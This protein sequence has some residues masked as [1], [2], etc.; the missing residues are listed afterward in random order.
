VS[1]P[2]YAARLRSG[3]WQTAQLWR[4]LRGHGQVIGFAT[5]LTLLATA[6]GL[7]QPMLVR[8]VIDAAQAGTIAAGLVTTLLAVLVGQAAI[9]AFG[10][11]LLDRTSEGILLSLRLRLIGHLIRLHMRVYDRQRIGDLI[12]RTSTDTTIVR[13]A[14][15]NSFS[16]LITN[17]IGV[18]GAVALMVWLDPL[19]FLLVL[20]VVSVASAMMLT[21]LVRIR[22]TSARGQASIGGMTAELERAL[23]AIRT[24]RACRAEQREAERI[25]ARAC[26][27]NRAGVRMAKLDSVIA[28][29]IELAVNGSILV[30]LLIGGLRVAHGSMSL[31]DLVAFLLYVTYL[32]VPLS[33]LFHAMAT[34]QRGLGAL[35]RVNSVFAMPCEPDESLP[36]GAQLA[37]P[38][39]RPVADPTPAVEFRDV[40]FGY[41]DRP[42]LRGVSFAVP[43]RGYIA[44]VGRSGAG[45]STIF[46]LIERFYEHDSGE[47]R[48]DGRQARSMKRSDARALVNLVEQQAPVLHGTLRDNITYAVPDAPEDELRW[49]VKAASLQELVAR[50]PRG[51]DTE[52]G[53]HGSALSGG[54]RQRVAIARAL[55]ARPAVLLMDEPTSQL[56]T[57]NEVALTAVMREVASECALFVI[58]HRVST[59]RAADEII[60]LDEGKVV[61]T[62]RHV[63]LVRTN[64]KY[65]RLTSSGLEHDL[66][67]KPD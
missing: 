4:L 61:A 19:L 14:A 49:A 67:S 7:L 59:V 56:D 39:L 65:Q 17:A 44:L 6:A 20:L 9:E 51:L 13:E 38:A 45:K 8:Q 46:E 3:G 50:L 26:D 55:L 11:Y 22:A 37:R 16:D 36:S 54:E 35:E 2:G 43:R 40:W 29:A 52:V 47:I 58:A 32:V 57:V 66:A 41:T 21:V 34:V 33:S 64:A 63:D 5:L 30:V 60:V 12:S 18:L 48:I 25:G 1:E 42:V 27:A 24:V 23:T 31:G 15:A 62:G 10:R 28:P 53:D